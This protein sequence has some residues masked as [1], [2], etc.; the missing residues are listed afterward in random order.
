[1]ETDEAN[2]DKQRMDWIAK[3][4]AEIYRNVSGWH[5][6]WRNG[7]RVTCENAET[8]RQAID[9]ARARDAE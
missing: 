7:D 8:L 1:M 9:Q 3:A 4:R 5:V 2:A 6:F